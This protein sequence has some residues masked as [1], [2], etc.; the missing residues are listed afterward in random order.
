MFPLTTLLVNNRII[1]IP[2]KIIIPV[3]AI[4]KF[5]PKGL[6]HDSFEE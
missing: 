2:I 4:A 1:N 5:I 3:N 6:N